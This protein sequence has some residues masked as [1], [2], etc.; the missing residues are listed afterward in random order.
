MLEYWIQNGETVIKEPV[1][2]ELIKDAL[3][4]IFQYGGGHTILSKAYFKQLN[5]SKIDELVDYIYDSIEGENVSKKNRRKEASPE[6]CSFCNESSDFELKGWI[7]P[8]IIAKDNF[9]NLYSNGKI[10][11]K[12]CKRCT[13]K[14]ILALKRVRFS[15]QKIGDNHYLC[16]VMFF[17]DTVDNLRRFYNTLQENTNPNYGSNLTENPIDHIYYPYEL[18]TTLLYDIA[19]KTEDYKYKLGAIVVGLNMNSKKIYDVVDVIDDLNP[20]IKAFKELY[21]KNDKAFPAFFR[22]RERGKIDRDISIKRNQEREIDI[23]IKRNLFFKD[24]LK[25]R[26]INWRVIEDVLFYNISNDMNIRF[27]L[28]PFLHTIMEQ[29]NMSEKELFETVSYTGYKLGEALLVS[30][31]NNRERVKQLLYELRRKRKMEEFLDAIN[32]IQIK[33]GRQFN[34]KPFKDN[35]KKFNI[36]KTF[37]L[38]GMTNAIFSRGES[39][40]EI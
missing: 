9:P 33:A 38:I 1:T 6:I 28:S 16:Y 23:S 30:E 21:N 11:V 31:N 7:F 25:L 2:K 37:F 22:M 14:S 40:N 26:S 36:L 39:N 27:I 18:I 32:L 3:T 35:P 5:K 12:I 29:L 8:F 17:A 19:T 10:G 4:P 13:Y 20:M 24:L 34:D 15:S